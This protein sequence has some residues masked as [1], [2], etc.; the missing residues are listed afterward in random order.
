MT[1]QAQID[2]NRKNSKKSTGPKD[3]SLTSSNALKH[4]LTANRFIVLPGENLSEYEALVESLYEDYKPQTAVEEV[5]IDRMASAIWRQWR[6]TKAEN[7]K[8]EER[9]AYAPLE[10]ASKE[11]KRRTRARLGEY[12]DFIPAAQYKPTA[13]LQAELVGPDAATQKARWLEENGP[14]SD[15]DNESLKV[16][17]ETN[18]Y[19][20]RLY[21]TKLLQPELDDLSMRY[22]ASLE[23]EF[24]RALLTLMKIQADRNGFVSQKSNRH[25]PSN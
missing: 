10:Y 22:E 6:L 11:A 17:K 16:L 3:T 7:A 9:L 4:G 15:D 13:D 14:I 20:K 12:G 19:R 5:L 18:E 25:Q 8:I 21:C 24:Y 23:R 2:A 1:S